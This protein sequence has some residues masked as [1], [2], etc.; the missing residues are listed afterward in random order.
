M[1]MAV[2]QRKISEL[3]P[4]D[5]NPRQLTKKQL[6]DLIESFKSL[7]TLE[8]AVINQY[9]GRENIIISGHQRI[10]VAQVM[11]MKEYP[12]I[13]V[14]FPLKKEKEANIRMN[15]NTG[16]WDTDI[17]ANEFDTEDLIDWGMDID[18]TPDTEAGLTDEDDVPPEPEEPTTKPGD[19]YQLG[20]HRLLCGDS[21]NIQHVEQLMDGEKAN[22]MMTSPPYWVGKD[23]E[24]QENEQE[25]DV[26]VNG[27]IKACLTA[28]NKDEAR[29]VIN[30]GTGMATRIKEKKSRVILIIDKWVN[31]L[32]KNG[33]LLRNIRHWLKGGGSAGPISAKTDFVYSGM[34]YLLSF[35]HTDGNQRGQNK[36]SESWCQQP[37]WNDIQGDKQE[38]KAGFPVELPNRFILL[39]SLDGEIVFDQFGGNGTTLIA[40]EKTQRVCRMMELDPK[41][42]D[43]IVK[44]WEEYTGKKA[45]LLIEE[46]A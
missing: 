12:C 46:M 5:Y 24:T 3:R 15:A 16:E 38:N 27:I 10:K 14:K 23:Y 42:C 40:C 9:K 30:S 17:L 32:Y 20:P 29:I 36:I 21:T 7:G 41:Y 28:M 33:W 2:I 26:F 35:Y 11:D 25:I 34:E 13:E 44:R 22:L 39:Y 19:L 8:P 18:F 4:A 31:G 37:N 1:A 6:N 45:E 43:V